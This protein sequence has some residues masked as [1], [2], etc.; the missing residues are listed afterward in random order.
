MSEENKPEIVDTEKAA[1]LIKHLNGMSPN[2]L[3]FAFENMN[4]DGLL[5]I[6]RILAHALVAI[7]ND[8]KSKINNRSN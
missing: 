4:Y 3:G 7:A 8:V 1:E 5:E 2:E 6:N